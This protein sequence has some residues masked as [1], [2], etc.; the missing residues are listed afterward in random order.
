MPTPEV[1]RRLNPDHFPFLGLGIS[2]SAKEAV[3]LAPKVH[4]PGT[5]YP[6]GLGFLNI[7]INARIPL[8]SRLAE[9]LREESVPHVLHLEDINLVGK[10]DEER[11]AVVAEQAATLGP[12]WIEEDLGYWV[13]NDLP[14]GSEMLP[15]IF[16]RSSARQAVRNARR[17]MEVLGPRL[18]VENPPTNYV[19]GDLDLLSFMDIVQ[20]ET[21]C[22]LLLDL[23]HLVGY[24]LA[25]GRDP[26]AYVKGWRGLEAVIE[27][28]LAGHYV[29]RTNRGPIWQDSHADFVQPQTLQVLDAAMS[30]PNNVRA[31]TLEVEAANWATIRHNVG[32]VSERVEAVAVHG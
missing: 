8:P 28:H 13:R 1:E 31:I 12:A 3:E 23:G 22:G 24:A 7:G 16:D 19:L 29:L 5:E 6:A 32:L 15:P 27:V 25:T 20:G 17:I 11:L 26:V 4:R 30:R 2:A 9:V 14:L 10:L 21:G 18:L